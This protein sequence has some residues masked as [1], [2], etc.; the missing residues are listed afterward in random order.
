MVKKTGNLVV[1]SLGIG[2]VGSQLSS[3]LNVPA[4]STMT[5]KFLE[6][7][8]KIVQPVLKV[9]GASMIVSST[10]KLKKSSKKLLKGGTF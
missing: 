8:S 5:G 2:V 4:G 6:G 1:T 9:K 10:S 7:S 3:S